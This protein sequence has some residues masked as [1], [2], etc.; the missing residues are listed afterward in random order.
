MYTADTSTV[1]ELPD[2]SVFD[3]VE[4]TLEYKLMQ[5]YEHY[6]DAFTN[7]P[8]GV[9]CNQTFE[10][11]THPVKTEQSLEELF[12]TQKKNGKLILYYIASFAVN[13]DET[14]LVA[15]IA[16]IKNTKEQK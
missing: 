9:Y 15:R 10:V 4:T 7:G 5:K 3:T 11:Q 2:I 8:L 12:Q 14:M 6:F 13:D 1:N 16:V